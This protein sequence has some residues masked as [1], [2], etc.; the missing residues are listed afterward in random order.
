MKARMIVSISTLVL[1]VSII[2]GS[3][4]TGK[5]TYKEDYNFIADT[6]INEE[7]NSHPFPAKWVMCSDGTFDGYNK[8]S[9][10]GISE[11]GHYII[12]DKWTDP[13]GNIWYKSNEWVGDMVEG[14]PSKYSPN[15]LSNSGDVWEYI[16]FVD[17]YPIEM[18]KSIFEYHIYYRQ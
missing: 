5:K 1:P 14:K 3:C 2:T 13:E 16:S 17:D 6:W 8:L 9:D 11:C 18:D 10:I 7:Y 15:K 12:T 4:A